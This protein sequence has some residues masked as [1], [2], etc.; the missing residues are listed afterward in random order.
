MADSS[1]V[2]PLPQ[3]LCISEG[4]HHTCGSGFTREAGAA[5][6]GPSTPPFFVTITSLRA[7]SATAK[8]ETA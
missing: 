8:M 6:I 2:N 1:R 7:H 3:V 5:D 4:L